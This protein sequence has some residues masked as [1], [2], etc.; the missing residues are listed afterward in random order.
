[1]RRGSRSASTSLL[2]L[3]AAILAAGAGA[4]GFAYA[5]AAAVAEHSTL[6][7]FFQ[8]AFRGLWLSDSL[9]SLL[10]AIVLVSIAAK[11]KLAAKPL[12]VLLAVTP[13]GM[14]VVLFSTMGL[15]F[16]SYLM[17]IAAALALLAAALRPTDALSEQCEPVVG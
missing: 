13:L 14:A 11:P 8:A 12:V 15:F 9:S 3:S 17:L 4:H 2:I 7:P 1:M 5:K 6:P 16:A 10:L